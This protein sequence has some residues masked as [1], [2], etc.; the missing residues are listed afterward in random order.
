MNILDKLNIILE[1][2]DN[3]KFK[4]GQTTDVPKELIS[5]AQKELA[6]KHGRK[7]DEFKFYS[8]YVPGFKNKV[9]LLFNVKLFTDK[10]TTISYELNDKEK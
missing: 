9:F 3:T 1:E 5:K 7:P 6:R 4:N 2:K 10:P 8:V